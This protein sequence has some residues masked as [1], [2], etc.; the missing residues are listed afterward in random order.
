MCLSQ[1]APEIRASLTLKGP[2]QARRGSDNPY[3]F[4]PLR[5]GT[6]RNQGV[7]GGVEKV[8]LESPPGLSQ[9]VTWLLVFSK[10]KPK[11]SG[12]F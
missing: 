8:M 5:P 4:A 3:G 1:N 6:Y 12:M 10:T 7:V 11:Q 2:G 9:N